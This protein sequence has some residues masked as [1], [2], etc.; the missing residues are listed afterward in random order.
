VELSVQIITTGGNGKLSS[1]ISPA[2]H[3]LNYKIVTNSFMQ[4]MFC[5]HR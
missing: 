3:Q 2:L 4:L 1:W 5:E